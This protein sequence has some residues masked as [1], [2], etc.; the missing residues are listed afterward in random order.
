[1]K[2]VILARV[3]QL[4]RQQIRSIFPANL[5]LLS[6]NAPLQEKALPPRPKI[7]DQDI[8]ESFLKGSGPGGQKIN[9]TNSAVQI[10]H[11]PTGIVVK[12]QETRSR[13]LN[14]K[15]ARNILAEKLDQLANGDQSRSAIKLERARVKKASANKKSKRKYKKLAAEKEQ[16]DGG[17]ADVDAIETHDPMLEAPCSKSQDANQSESTRKD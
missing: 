4:S 17:H 16:N 8:E 1:M 12:C 15:F 3:A 10:K 11:L 13:E 6:T 9:K 2:T 14:R 7:L 5:C